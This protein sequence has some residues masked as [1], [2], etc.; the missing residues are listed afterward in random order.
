MCGQ[1]FGN[2]VLVLEYH[3]PQGSSGELGDCSA[4]DTDPG[5]GVTAG[6]GIRQDVACVGANPES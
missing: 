2:Q 6:Y 4:Y 3:L 5:L 1:E